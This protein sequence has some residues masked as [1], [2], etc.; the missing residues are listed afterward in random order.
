MQI[1]KDLNGFMLHFIKMEVISGEVL[2]LI[3]T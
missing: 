2:A 3:K 1:E